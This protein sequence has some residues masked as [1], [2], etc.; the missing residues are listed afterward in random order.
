MPLADLETLEYKLGKRGFR[1]DDLYF[2][3]CD[4][5]REQAVA[6][7]VIL[8]RTGGRDIWL[9]HACGA[10]RSFRNGSGMNDREE[11]A[12]FDLRAFLA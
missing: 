2:H 10:A 11:D 8:G 4:A 6:K 1:R 5:C 9:C 7:Y 12:G 3:A